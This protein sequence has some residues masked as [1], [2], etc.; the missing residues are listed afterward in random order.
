MSNRTS[1]GDLYL[2][3][4]LNLPESVLAGS[5]KVD[6]SEGIDQVE[7]SVDQ[8]V[9][10]PNIDKALRRALSVVRESVR[11][12]KP[13]ASYLHGSFGSGKSHFM[14]V[15]HA[16]LSNSPAARGKPTLQPIIADHDSWLRDRKFLKVPFHLVG[17]TDLDSAILG[18]YVR[19]IREVEPTASVPP[20]YRAD[21]MLEDAR[22]QREFFQDDAQFVRWLG[23]PALPQEEAATAA[24]T[25]EDDDLDDLEDLDAKEAPKVWT[26]ALLDEAFDAAPGDKARDW[27]ASALLSGPYSSY[28]QGALGA[29]DAFLP[30]ENGLDIIS[31]HAKSL[32]YDGLIL[33][34][35]EVILWLQA[36]LKDRTFVNNE[37]NKL[38]KLIESGT[39]G[40]PLPIVS[41]I[42]R[43]RDLS[44]LI[45][46]NTV[47]LDAKNLEGQLK[48]L[49]GRIDPID[50]EDRNLPE[51]VKERVLKP[52]DDA[53]RAALDAAFAGIETS[54]QSVRDVLLDP[55][56]A[57]HADWADFK[58]LY[59]VSP[60]LLNVLV[61]LSGALQRERTGLK[62]LQ[63]LLY[64]RRDDL[65]VGQLIPLGD[66]WD[67]LA[68]DLK[69]AFTERLTHEAEAADRF[70]GKVREFLLEKYG[71]AD[72]P[73]F[74]ADERFVKTLLLAYLAPE[75]PALARLTGPRLSALNHGSVRS[76]TGQEDRIVVTRLRD[77]QAH[78]PGELRTEGTADPVFTLHLS[79]LDVEPIL[80]SVGEKDTV[81][82]R[83]RWVHEWLWRELGVVDDGGF[84]ATREIVWHGT[85]RTAEFVFEN[86]R[87][88]QLLPSAQF[89]PSSADRIRFVVDYPFDEE[90]SPSA[91][92]NRVREL[93]QEKP[94]A[95]T[96]VWIPSFLATQ[97]INQ[98]G[99]LLKIDYLL[100]RD[101]LKD[102]ATHLSSDDQIRVR[103]QLE[104]Q[105]ETLT[106]NL[107]TV[108]HQAYGI[109]KGSD[110]DLGSEVTDG[111]HVHALYAGHIPELH[112]GGVFE[113]NLL[114]L[115]DGLLDAIYPKHP[116]FDRAENRKPV[117]PAQ[118]KKAYGW[119]V[120]AMDDGSRRVV[121]DSSDLALVAKIVHPLELGEVHDGPLNVSTDWRRAIEQQAGKHQAKGDFKAED[122]RQWI[123]ELGWTGL[124]RIVSNLVIATY[125]L[126][127]DR[128]WLY[129]G[130]PRPAPPLDQIGPGWTLRAQEL[131]G[132]EEFAAA[133]TRAAAV[134]GTSVPT[135]LFARNVNALAEHVREKAE[136]REDAVDE[137]RRAL[138]GYRT[139]LGITGT[140]PTA[141]ERAV[142]DAA[143]LLA[144]IRQTPEPTPLARDLAAASYATTDV[145]LAK[146]V[147]SAQQVLAALD[148]TDWE[149]VDSL[150]AY[151]GRGD[152]LADRSRHLLAEIAEAAAKDEFDT[153]LAPVL[154]GTRSRAVALINEAA[155]L[156]TVAQ[157]T[158]P[159]AP[160]APRPADAEDVSL[161]TH[162]EPAVPS[163]RPDAPQWGAPTEPVARRARKVLA[164]GDSSV[165]EETLGD[166]LS[167]VQDEIRT[168]A[169]AHPGVEIEINWTVV[170]PE[171]AGDAGGE[172]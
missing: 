170:N 115:A 98:L 45:G 94:Q 42:S 71:S 124:D 60:V 134:F 25:P 101:H 3:D 7:E 75:V 172:S 23:D 148:G 61:A 112:R 95:A 120:K 54:N 9:V 121:V 22:R 55:Q 46:A 64:K 88:R 20:V 97:R 162:A 139:S 2:R 62:L 43:Q 93:Q 114:K 108:L 13:N 96:I 72:D 155:R 163:T 85:K 29:K 128:S 35:D 154:T 44:E 171:T 8:Y 92:E 111:R 89:E 141:R 31:R 169:A 76:R 50:L 57:T 28:T 150:S 4:V 146:T 70:H 36:H 80:D 104:A 151:T 52:K 81:P 32:G 117:T 58:A 127:A 113:Y 90:G 27:L 166:A 1:H 47:G 153:A 87:D 156:S 110:T 130:E 73:K 11:T 159:P 26:P 109:N 15:L 59:P 68:E 30:L 99:R 138:E 86:V 18:G 147:S 16:I 100:D 152:T 66:L 6:L 135:V 83:K 74:I 122:I 24:S 143:D 91:D 123:A 161:T 53:A 12:G 157:P 149:L 10:T 5:F 33:F 82:A 78:F 140:E 158:P 116:N 79:D 103:H 118:F 41:F 160:V 48:Y 107:G 63:Q 51:I 56:G 34:I 125:A 133:H 21:A 102:F 19:Y 37:V 77:L 165:L 136:A 132:A 129:N 84:V 164:A 167:G 17:A 126:I 14:T 131:P 40:R 137:L 105:R 145:V 67:V 119:I 142:R 69:G 144:R 106:A 38:V 39:G 168:Y 65:K 49:A